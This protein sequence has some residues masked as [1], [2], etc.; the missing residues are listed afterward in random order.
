M[1]KFIRFL[2]IIFLI[3]NSA[4]A[5]AHSPKIF[6][7]RGASKNFPDNTISAFEEAIKAGADG[8]EL[9]VQLTKD[10]V[11]VLYHP[12][13]LYPYTG[14]NEKIS[15]LNFSELQKLSI[16]IPTLEE[17]IDKFFNIEIVVDLKSLPAN[18]L[19]DAII[20][21][22]DKKDAWKRLVFY[23]TNDEHLKYFIKHKP[24]AMVFESRSLTRERLL[25]SRN[26]NICCCQNQE[27]Q[28]VGFELDREMIV[29]ES[30]ALGKSSN[31]INFRLWD[32]KSIECFNNSAKG[33]VK[34]FLFGINDKESYEEAKKLNV[35]A[36]FT[37]KMQAL[38][39]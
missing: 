34:I 38:I 22:I 21:L 18:Q 20:K 36:V 14:T 33:K 8:I 29:E 11:A 1:S 26:E 32:P 4:F 39:N 37:D 10:K 30:F 2:M 15:D 19:I 23:S 3:I 28:Y 12:R 7:H 5:Y 25:K 27:R 31:K 6:A 13:D 24:E 16:K 17:A 9:D 35:Y